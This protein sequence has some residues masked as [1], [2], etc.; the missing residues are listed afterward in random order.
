MTYIITLKMNSSFIFHNS[1]IFE[2]NTLQ[3]RCT[4]V[5]CL[6]TENIMLKYENGL[7]P[8]HNVNKVMLQTLKSEIKNNI[9]RNIKN[10]QKP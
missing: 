5:V 6:A 7:N 4:H 2:K 9:Y 8:H 10:V 1:N 3:R